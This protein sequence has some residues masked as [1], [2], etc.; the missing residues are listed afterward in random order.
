MP[1]QV[2]DVKVLAATTSKP[3]QPNSSNNFGKDAIST[4]IHSQ[5]SN[6]AN[7]GV[8]DLNKIIECVEGGHTICSFKDAL[9]FKQ[10][11]VIFS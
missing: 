6:K 3:M 8:E 1:W 9:V 7:L 10:C 5:E 4:I 2:L 11:N